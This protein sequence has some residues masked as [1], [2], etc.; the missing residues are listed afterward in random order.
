M[1]EPIVDASVHQWSIDLE[2]MQ[3]M[4]PEKWQER[5]QIKSNVQDPVTGTV[6]PTLPWTHAYWNE[7]APNYDRDDPDNYSNSSVYR[8]PTKMDATLADRGVETAILMGHEIRFLPSL[9]SPEYS[10]VLARAYNELLTDR[11]LVESDRMKGGIVL[12][13]RNPEAAV[14]E[15]ETYA[16]HPD[17]VTAIIFTG[18][19]LPLGHEYHQPVFEAAADAGL[20][21]TIHLSGNPTFRQM[22]GG[23][24]RSYGTYDTNLV[25]SHIAS[26]VNL[27]LQGV[28][29]SNPDLQTVWVGAGA[30]WILHPMWRMSRYYRN[31]EPMVPDIEREPKEYIDRCHVVTYPLG[32]PDLDGGLFDLLGTEHILYGSGFPDWNGDTVDRLPEMP[33]REYEAIT[34]TNAEALFGL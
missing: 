19:P 14:T 32:D 33:D 25:Q 21:V 9:P 20:P 13:M 30:G 10:A 24:P 5:L 1:P 7:D 12:P 27:V 15:I 28:Y 4:V 8:S 34:R 29:D 26:F 11:W 23:L 18:G 6:M 22:A 17:I 16:D 31:L 3:D 2:E